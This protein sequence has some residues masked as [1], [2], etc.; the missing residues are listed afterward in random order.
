MKLFKNFIFLTVTPLILFVITS[1]LITQSLDDLKSGYVNITVT[2]LFAIVNFVFIYVY[3]NHLRKK[4]NIYKSISISI[5]LILVLVFSFSQLIMSL[6]HSETNVKVSVFQAILFVGIFLFE[7]AILKVYKKNIEGVTIE[8]KEKPV[9]YVKLIGGLVLFLTVFLIILLSDSFNGNFIFAQIIE[10]F[11]QIGSYV[12][13]NVV[14]CFMTL[15]CLSKIQAVNK[16]VLLITMLSTFFQVLIN[17]AVLHFVFKTF[18]F[19]TFHSFFLSLFL[20]GLVVGLILYRKNIFEK[21]QQIE[22]LTFSNS[23]KEADYRV[24]K[25]QIN[26]HFLFNNLNTLI[27]FIESDPEKAVAFGHHL[28]NVYRH[29]LKK[30]EADFVLLNEELD[31][32]AEY[33]AIY[34]AKFDNGIKYNIVKNN[35]DQYYVVS[36]CLQELID[37]IFKHNVSDNENVL[38]ISIKV[39]RESLFIIN[40]VIKNSNVITNGL[41]LENIK[42]R[43]LYL[44]NKEVRIKEDS[45]IFSVELPLFKME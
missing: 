41:G 12:L 15:Y 45:Q 7:I 42:K 16:N 22:A 25:N 43:Y 44:T 28:S 4:Y 13:V 14:I 31:F 27:S 2:G 21:E 10:L 8:F 38:E 19:A 24:L 5:F 39:E 18:H 26:P 36:N 35:S 3:E 33:L 32:L 29:Y 6:F 17:A 23:Q 40:S 11:R 20:N 37:N 9:V 34:K 1:L 30:Q